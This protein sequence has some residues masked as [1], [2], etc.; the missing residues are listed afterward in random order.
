MHKKISPLMLGATMYM[1]ATRT[2]IV[3]K[4]VNGDTPGLSSV[5]ICLEDAVS[6]HEVPMALNNLKNITSDLAALKRK[7]A[8]T[9]MPLIFVRPRDQAMAQKIVH[10]YDLSAID[11]MVLPKFT[12]ES[13][14]GWW[15][16]LRNTHL[17]W[18]PTLETREVFCVS[19]MSKLAEALDKHSCKEKILALRIGGND[20]M[21]VVSLRR[22]RNM[23]LYDTPMGYV[24]KMLVAVMSPYGFAMTAPV[25]EHIDHHDILIKE[26]EMDMAHGLV[27]KTAIHPSQIAVIQTPMMVDKEDH[28]DALHILNS[29]KAVFKSHGAMCEPATHKNWATAVLTRAQ[30]FGIRNPGLAD[31][32]HEEAATTIGKVAQA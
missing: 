26:W 27:G 18:M 5:V 6:E 20:L 29:D 30:H 4:L 10:D 28:K 17:M 3:S 15:S 7:G 19:Q 1:P 14:E 8:I 12:L 23:T 2:D 21:N 25:C 22:P 13:L 9:S 32:E 11:G 31:A 24:I 16:I